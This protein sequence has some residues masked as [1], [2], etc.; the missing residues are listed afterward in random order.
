MFL[1][2][3]DF[4]ISSKT[5]FFLNWVIFEA[6]SAQETQLASS[7]E[8]T[9]VIKVKYSYKNVEAVKTKHRRAHL[10]HL[11]LK[12]AKLLQLLLY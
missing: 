8:G 10:V 11:S 6:Y 5:R 2:P 7:V 1:S 9:K 3:G 4:G 12:S